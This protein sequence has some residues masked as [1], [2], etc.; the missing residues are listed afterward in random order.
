MAEGLVDGVRQL[1]VQPVRVRRYRH[2]DFF[3]RQDDFRVMSRPLSS[4]PDLGRQGKAAPKVR[5]RKNPDQSFTV[6]NRPLY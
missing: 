1:V 5:Y 2:R 6:D 4:Q 3:G